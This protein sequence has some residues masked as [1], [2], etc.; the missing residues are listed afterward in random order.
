MATR[1]TSQLFTGIWLDDDQDNGEEVLLRRP[2]LAS[3]GTSGLSH[4]FPTPKPKSH[5]TTQVEED[6]GG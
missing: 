3:D 5:A 4:V 6:K 2:I 1:G